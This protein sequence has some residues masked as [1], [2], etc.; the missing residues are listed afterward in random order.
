[1]LANVAK[2]RTKVLPVVDQ[3]VDHMIGSVVIRGQRIAGNIVGQQ[4]VVIGDSANLCPDDGTLAVRALLVT[5]IVECFR[6]NAPLNGDIIGGVPRFNILISRPANRTM[7]DNYIMV[8]LNPSPQQP[9]SAVGPR[10]MRSPRT[11]ASCVPTFRTG[12]SNR[13]SALSNIPPPGAV[14][15]AIVI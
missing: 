2:F 11:V 5:T 6:D 13:G 12:P 8:M 3:I 9:F 7:I 10:R 15:P 14:C 1:M 4:I